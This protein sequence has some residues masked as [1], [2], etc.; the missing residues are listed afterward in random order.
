MELVWKYSFSYGN[1]EKC[2]MSVVPIG[3]ALRMK[4]G[5]QRKVA[6]DTSVFDSV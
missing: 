1:Y 6:I 4:V 5:Q 2:I 3:I